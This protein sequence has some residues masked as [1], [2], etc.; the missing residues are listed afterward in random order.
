MILNFMLRPLP[1][2][3]TLVEEDF[4]YK[5]HVTFSMARDNTYYSA[6]TGTINV[7]ESDTTSSGEIKKLKATFS[8]KTDTLS[9]KF[10]SITEGIINFT[11]K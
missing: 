9:G 3:Y 1:G 7:T 6:V 5:N 11:K 10:Y 8:F 4:T 2:I